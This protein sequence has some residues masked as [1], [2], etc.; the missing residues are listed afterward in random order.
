MDPTQA[1]QTKRFNDDNKAGLKDLRMMWF[2]LKRQED[3]IKVA[4][5]YG[6]EITDKM[7]VYSLLFEVQ[8]KKRLQQVEV[9]RKPDDFKQKI[10]AELLRDEKKSTNNFRVQ[11]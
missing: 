10:V 2:A 8:N 11:R 3:Y 9:S 4:S 1:N 7:Q 6:Y 5:D